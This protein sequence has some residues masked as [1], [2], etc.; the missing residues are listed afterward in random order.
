MVT[1]AV[2]INAQ[3]VCDL[4]EKVRTLNPGVPITLILDNARYQQCKVV[5]DKA[6]LL[7]IELLYLPPYSPDYS[8]IENCWTWNEDIEVAVLDD[9]SRLIDRMVELSRE[10]AP[11][12]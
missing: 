10:T 5:W 6:H 3:S 1:N 2:Y 7:E 9:I 11:V 8:P 4:L 12:T